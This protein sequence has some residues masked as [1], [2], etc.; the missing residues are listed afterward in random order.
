MT[1]AR[2]RGGIDTS[3]LLLFGALGLLVVLGLALWQLGKPAQPGGNHTTNAEGTAQPDGGNQGLVLFCAAGIRKP[4]AE[5]A[6]A[7]E[8]EFG[9]P[10]QLQYDGSNTLLSQLE[11]A[12]TGD[13]FLAADDFYTQQAKDKGLMAESLAVAQM[14]PVIM[15]AAGN[16]K[17]IQGVADL[18]RSDV[19]TALGNPDQA[20]IGKTTR[21][22]LQ[23]SGEWEKLE[24]HVRQ[25]GVFKPTVPAIA[26]DVELGSVDAAIV[27]DTTLKLYPKTEAIR[28]P[29]LDAGLS[30]VTIGVLTSTRQPTAALKFARYLTAQDKGLLTFAEHGFQT[31][32]GD[33]WAEAPELTFFCGAVNRRA[34]DEVIK[35]FEQ[36]EGVRVNTVYNGCGILTAQMRTIRG[37]EQGGGFPDTYMACDRYYLDTVKDWFQDDADI[38]DTEVVIAVPKGNPAGIKSLQDLTKPGVRVSVGQPEQCTI[39][40]LTR[41]VLESEGIY[42]AVMKNVATQ[43]ASSSLLIPTVS[44]GSVDATLAYATD[45]KAEADKVDTIRIGTDSAKAVQPF[46]I[47]RGSHFKH[48]GK[49]LYDKIASSRAAF[50]DAGFHFRVDDSQPAGATQ[51]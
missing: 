23:K 41:Q 4:V 2:R 24:A 42:D 36:R 10:V 30:D 40:V 50:E 9:V 5:I 15:V 3:Y 8:K 27:W 17:N 14:R 22:L 43:T 46:A 32:E 12:H 51:P 1:G 7:Y 48:L 35:Q 44:T 18:L 34:V 39:G 21:S 38:S 31:V 47:A 6:A 13:L 26:T 45:T 29:E 20:A 37:Q 49:R 16:P 28:A 11:V 25:T 33:Q 19:T